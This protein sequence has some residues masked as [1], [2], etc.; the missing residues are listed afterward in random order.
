MVNNKFASSFFYDFDNVILDI[1]VNVAKDNRV[2]INY[3]SV[4]V[5]L[6]SMSGVKIISALGLLLNMQHLEIL[7][8]FQYL[9]L[10]R[11]RNTV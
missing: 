3:D 8:G 9:F 4:F 2:I 6:V 10:L 11:N 7:H 1:L 5:S